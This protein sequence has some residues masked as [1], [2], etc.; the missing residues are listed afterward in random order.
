MT[1]TD[2]VWNEHWLDAG[3]RYDC[4]VVR[5]GD[6]GKLSVTLLGMVDH[7]LHREAVKC[8]RADTDHWRRHCEDVIA[9]PDLRSYP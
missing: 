3:A 9:H 2:V 1:M 5:D 4:R 6:K 7:V 8:D